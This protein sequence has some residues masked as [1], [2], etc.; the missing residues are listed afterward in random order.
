MLPPHPG[1]DAQALTQ[2]Q[3]SSPQTSAESAHLHMVAALHQLLD[4]DC[5]LDVVAPAQLQLLCHN[6]HL[7]SNMRRI[8]AQGETHLRVSLSVLHLQVPA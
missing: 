2:A 4:H 7:G 1:R 3:S 6:Y 8:A 5:K